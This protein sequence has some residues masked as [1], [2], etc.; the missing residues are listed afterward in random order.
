MLDEIRSM[1]RWENSNVRWTE[2]YETAFAKFYETK[3]RSYGMSSFS[4][5]NSE[6]SRKIKH[7]SRSNNNNNKDK[8]NTINR[9]DSGPRN[10]KDVFITGVSTYAQAAKQGKSRK[11]GKDQ[12]SIQSSITPDPGYQWESDDVTIRHHKREPRGQ[13][14]PS[15]RPQGINKQTCMKV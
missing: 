5:L 14:F 10:D 12:D 11:D 13:P 6:T 2:N 1:K 9:T 7:N 15:R 8:N 4:H 3:G